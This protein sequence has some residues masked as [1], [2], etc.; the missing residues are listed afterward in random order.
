MKKLSDEELVGYA[1]QYC[2]PFGDGSL[3]NPK[4]EL[5][6]RLAKGRKAEELVKK[7]GNYIKEQEKKEKDAQEYRDFVEQFDNCYGK[8]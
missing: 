7:Y 4:A 3:G 5:I 2:I 8:E 6:S 1:F